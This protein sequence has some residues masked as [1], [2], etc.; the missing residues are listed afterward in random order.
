MWTDIFSFRRGRPN[1][2]GS[3]SFHLCLHPFWSPVSPHSPSAILV[4]KKEMTEPK[5]D[6]KCIFCKIIKGEI[7]SIK[8]HETKLSLAF[9]DLNPLSQGHCLVIPK[10]HAIKTHELH[11]ETMADVGRTLHKVSKAVVTATKCENYN[12]LQNNG[13][14]AGQVVMHVHYHIIPK[15]NKAEGLGVKWPSKAADKDELAQLGKTIAA[16]VAKLSVASGL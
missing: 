12:I 3:S 1:S 5:L 10:E 7:P 13:S 16:A 4:K 11:E 14:E 6:P 2:A 8:L 15:P 9:M